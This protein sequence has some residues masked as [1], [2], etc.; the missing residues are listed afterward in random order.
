ML[1]NNP[2]AYHSKHC[3]ERPSAAALAAN[4]QNLEGIPA[5]ELRMECFVACI[6]DRV[7]PATSRRNMSTLKM[8]FN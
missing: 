2:E 5:I 3:A 1:Q 8:S 7:L 4:S 6:S